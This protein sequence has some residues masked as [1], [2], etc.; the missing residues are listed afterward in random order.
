VARRTAWRGEECGGSRGAA[1]E[2][3]GRETS[4]WA[5]GPVTRHYG[6]AKGYLSHSLPTAILPSSV[7]GKP[8]VRGCSPAAEVPGANK[9]GSSLAR[10]LWESSA[11][12]C[13]WRSRPMATPP[14]WVGGPI[15]ARPGRHGGS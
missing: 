15:T 3:R 9:A 14:W 13:Q 10:V 12:A 1:A 8:K 5:A 11:K 6:Q 4:G 2:G 7:G